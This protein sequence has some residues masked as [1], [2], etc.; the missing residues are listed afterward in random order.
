MICRYFVGL[1]MNHRRRQTK[2]K[3]S[4]GMH[5]FHHPNHRR[6]DLRNQTSVGSS[7]PVLAGSYHLRIRR[8][9]RR[10]RLNLCLHVVL[11]LWGMHRLHLTIRLRHHLNIRSDRRL[12][13]RLLRGTCRLGSR[14]DC[15]HNH[16]HQHLRVVSPRPGRRQRLSLHPTMCLGL[17]NHRHQSLNSQ[18]GLQP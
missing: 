12:R 10:S 5:R 14:L 11:I 7:R 15:H 9:N 3:S 6:Q 4:A 13:H 17:T 1:D 18:V 8:L 2:T 16:H